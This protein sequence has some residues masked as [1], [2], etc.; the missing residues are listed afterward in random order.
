MRRAL[1]P[2][3]RYVDVVGQL[4]ETFGDRAE[5]SFKKLNMP[6]DVLI[7]MRLSVQKP[8]QVRYVCLLLPTFLCAISCRASPLQ[9]IKV[10]PSCRQTRL[11]QRGSQL[12]SR[13]TCFDAPAAGSWLLQGSSRRRGNRAGMHEAWRHHFHQAG[14]A[15][16][17]RGCCRLLAPLLPKSNSM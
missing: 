1:P 12:S 6:T 4:L 5:R 16:P 14:T 8:L 3:Q 13:R 11:H 10:V 7:A 9:R 17:L 15:Q 2:L